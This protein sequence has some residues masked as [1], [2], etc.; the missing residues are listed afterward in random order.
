MCTESD[1]IKGKLIEDEEREQGSVSYKV[2]L[3]YLRSTTLPLM[4][5]VFAANTLR[6]AFEVATSFWLS[7]WASDNVNPELNVSSRCLGLELH[8]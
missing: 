1:D 8:Y 4:L 2:Y 7:K 6:T 5:A 3:F